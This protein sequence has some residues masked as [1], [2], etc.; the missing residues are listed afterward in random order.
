VVASLLSGV[1][2]TGHTVRDGRARLPQTVSTIAGIA[3][4]ASVPAAMFTGVP[5]SFEAFGFANRWDSFTQ[6]PPNEGRLASAPIDDA[7][8]WLCQGSDQ[9]DQGRPR[10]AVVHARG[11]HPPWEVT[12]NEAAKLPP[13][14]YTG[15]LGPRRAAQL[16]A[17]VGGRHSRLS[18]ADRERMRALYFVGLS[19]QDAALGKLIQALQ[20]AGRWDSTL[21]IVTGDVA[22]GRRTLFGDGLDMDEGLL[23]IP[24]YVHF[25]GGIHGR[26]RLSQ[27]TEVYDLTRTVL[28]ALGLKPPPGMI[29]RDLASVAA[30]IDHETHHLRVAFT[31]DQFSVRWSEWV[32][33]GRLAERP[34]L[35]QL[36]LDPTCAYDHSVRFPIIAQALFRQLAA[37]ELRPRDV[38]D[39]EPAEITGEMAATLNVWGA[40]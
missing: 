15:Y 39:R 25:P 20:D 38:P 23:E 27:P 6:Y 12:P 32:L 3:R 24:L 1:S 16:L 9:P 22:S 26:E 34:K 36:S 7:A 35:C 2:P 17:K 31:E 33:Q 10:L 8:E 21:L 13:A 29:G 40:N 37:K 4:D 18:E 30:G 28:N 5:S 14:D 19:E 11:G